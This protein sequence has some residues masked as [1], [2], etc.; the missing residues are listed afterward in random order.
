MLDSPEDPDFLV[1]QDQEVQQAYL[2]HKAGQER[3]EVLVALVQAVPRVLL[4][5]QDPLA[6][7]V[8]LA[9][10]DPQVSI[11]SYFIPVGF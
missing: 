3:P 7:R 1:L 9:A 4:V 5:H 10:L 8:A 6:S 2:A 11:L